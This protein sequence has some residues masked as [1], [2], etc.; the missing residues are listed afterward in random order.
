MGRNLMGDKS[1][2]LAPGAE[3]EMLKSGGLIEHTQGSVDIV[4]LVGLLIFS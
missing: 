2:S 1:L 3:Q 4:S